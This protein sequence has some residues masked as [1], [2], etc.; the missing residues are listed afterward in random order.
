MIY[1]KGMKRQY[2]QCKSELSAE[3]QA[4]LN[5]IE[6][7]PVLVS[8]IGEIEDIAF[9]FGRGKFGGF[10]EDLDRLS[11]VKETILKILIASFML[12]KN[13][14]EA[15]ELALAQCEQADNVV[16]SAKKFVA[17]ELASKAVDRFNE[18]N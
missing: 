8:L 12:Q 10:G 6:E 15:L 5:E 11:T 2:E 14:A 4:K 16:E 3:H 1:G 9:K 13:G 7:L 17:A 18:R